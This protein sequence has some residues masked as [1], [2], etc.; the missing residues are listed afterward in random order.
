VAFGLVLDDD[1]QR[2]RTRSGENVHLADLL[3]EALSRARAFV[4]ERAAEHGQAVP[5]DIDEVARVVGLGAVKYA[6]LSQNRQSGYVFSFDRMLSLKGNT[7]PYLQ[8]AY[9][10]IR[11]ILR[12]AGWS[13]GPP[14]GVGARVTL[15]EPQERALAINLVMVGDVVERVAAEQLPSLLCTHLYELS[16]AY[17]QFYEHC[18]VLRS[19]EPLRSSRLALC[20]AAAATLARG[21]ALLGIEVLER[22]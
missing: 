5:E 19:D 15:G 2:L 9:A 6:D 16:Q 3:D 11:S 7:A 8:Y 4:A 20:E 14:G 1:G 13:E 18:P 22:I 12:E 10:R 21:L 17:N